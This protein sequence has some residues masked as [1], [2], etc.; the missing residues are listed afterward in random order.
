MTTGLAGGFAYAAIFG[1]IGRR[2]PAAVRWT[3]PLT[4]IGRRSLTC[5]LVMEAALILLQ[6]ADRPGG[7]VAPPA[8][9]PAAPDRRA[10]AELGWVIRRANR[11]AG[12]PGSQ[13]SISDHCRQIA[14]SQPR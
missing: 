13:T 5:C 7:V 11:P 12:V 8:G 6:A 2:V 4:A 14:S 3:R 1:L 9:Q 10:G